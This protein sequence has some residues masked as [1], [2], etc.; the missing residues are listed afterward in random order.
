MYSDVRFDYQK[1]DDF[2]IVYVQNNLVSAIFCL[3]VDDAEAED[4][5]VGGDNDDSGDGQ[6][7]GDEFNGDCDES[8]PGAG[9]GTC[10]GA[11]AAA[12]GC[13]GSTIKSSINMPLTCI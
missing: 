10:A 12:S 11:G 7:D 1:L 2:M 9:A 5:G 13:I 3:P 4:D 8:P 6:G